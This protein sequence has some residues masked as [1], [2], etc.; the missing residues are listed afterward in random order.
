MFFTLCRLIDCSIGEE[1]CAA[2]ISALRSNPS[3]LREL[4]LSSNKPGDSGVKLISALLEDPHCKLEKLWLINCSIGE[5]GCAALISA[6][7]LNPS[8]LRELD[9]SRNKPGDS[10]VNLI[11]ALLEDPH[12]KLEKLW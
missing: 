10:G 4:D 11:S 3:H 2:L 7:R 5:E 9:L 12:C 6:L 8:H 1:R